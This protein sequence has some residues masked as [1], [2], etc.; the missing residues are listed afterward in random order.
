MI[1]STKVNR[2]Q[3]RTS[4]RSEEQGV[5]AA[6][7]HGGGEAADRRGDVSAWR[8]GGA[9]AWSEREPSVWLASALSARTAGAEGEPNAGSAP[10]SCDGRGGKASTAMN[11]HG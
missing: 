1:V 4:Y 7:S 9:S 2:G 6:V 3:F 10:G 11:P 8:F 5:A